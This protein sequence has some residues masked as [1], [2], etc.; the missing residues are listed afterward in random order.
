MARWAARPR[1]GGAR[2]QG[3][4]LPFKYFP[5]SKDPSR[6]ISRNVHKG[7][8]QTRFKSLLLPLPEHYV[9]RLHH[10]PLSLEQ[11]EQASALEVGMEEG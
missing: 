2:E 9:G 7:Q 1:L 6:K 8:D 4:E 10:L 5:L 11:E 3:T